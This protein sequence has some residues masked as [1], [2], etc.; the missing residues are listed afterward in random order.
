MKKSKVIIALGIVMIVLIG[1]TVISKINMVKG[2][3]GETEYYIVYSNMLKKAGGILGIDVYGNKTEDTKLKIQD[4]AASDFSE[5][6]LSA[7]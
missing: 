3:N 7:R 4:I 1:I 5:G 6:V 2:T